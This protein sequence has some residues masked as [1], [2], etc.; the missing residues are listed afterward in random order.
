MQSLVQDLLEYSRVNTRGQT[1]VPINSEDIVDKVIQNLHVSIEETNAVIKSSHLPMVMADPTQITLVFQNILGNAIK[2]RK[3]DEPPY[4][5]ISAELMG[6]MWKFAVKDNGIGCE[7][8][9]S[10]ARTPAGRDPK[11]RSFD[12]ARKPSLTLFLF[13]WL[14]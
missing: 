7:G 10:N 14:L 4:V 1:F 3:K 8:C 5:S 11:S 6:D 12:L 13:S 2:F 9:D